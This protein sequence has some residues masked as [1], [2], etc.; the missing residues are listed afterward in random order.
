MLRSGFWMAEYLSISSILRRA[1]AQY[2]RSYLYTETDEGD[3]TYFVSHQ[4][5]VILE[6][7]D[8]VHRYILRKQKEQAAATALLKPGSPLAQQINYSQRALLLNA[9]KNPGKRFTIEMHQRSHGTSYQ[10]A[11]ADLLALAQ[12]GF[13]SYTR[14][15]K[16]FVFV[17]MPDLE[18]RLSH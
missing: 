7:I 1:P 8:G 18:K 6:A 9:L 15:G 4:L 17:A 5:D 16:A 14:E 10:T 13:L 2:M 12:G 3:T 11:R